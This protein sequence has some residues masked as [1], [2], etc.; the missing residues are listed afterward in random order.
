[1][2]AAVAPRVTFGAH[3]SIGCSGMG[4]ERRDDGTL[5]GFPQIGNVVIE[6]DV[7][8]AAHATV[9]RGAIGSTRIRRAPRSARM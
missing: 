9:Q 8:I 5:V 4:Y 6:A 1:M 2:N 3:C 7:D